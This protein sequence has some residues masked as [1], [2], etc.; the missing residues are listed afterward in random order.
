[1]SAILSAVIVSLAWW[2]GDMRPQGHAGLAL[3]AIETAAIVVGAILLIPGLIV[4][5]MLSAAIAWGGI[6]S[7]GDYPWLIYTTNWLFYFG[8]LY[9]ILSNFL[10]KPPGAGF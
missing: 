5:G 3:P 2:S 7:M 8:L 6:H 4:V 1:M 10:Q 9:R